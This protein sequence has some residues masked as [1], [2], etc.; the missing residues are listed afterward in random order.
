MPSLYYRVEAPGVNI[1]HTVTQQVVTGLLDELDLVRIFKDSVYILEPFSAYSQYDDGSGAPSLVKN[2]C[3]VEVN[4]IM[5][6]AQVPWPVETPY[7]TTA[8]GLRSDKKGNH[9]PILIDD[10]AQILIEHYTVACGLEMNFTLNFQTYDDA[11]KAFDTIKSKYHGSLIQ[12][13]FDISF[14]YPVSMA[15]L[16][17]L[18]AVYQAKTDYAS[19]TLIDYINDKKVT[20]ISF[21]VRKSELANEDADT[22]LMVRCQQL[23]CLGQ[24]TM[25]QREPDVQRVGQLPDSFTLNFTMVFQFGRPNLVAVHTP[26]S[27][28]NTVLPYALFENLIIN[29]HYNP[30][31]AGVYQDLMVSEFMK[32]SYGD[33]NRSAQIIR[34]PSYDDWFTADNQYVFYEYRPF[35]IAHFT[36]DGPT[37]TIDL[38]QLDDLELHPIVQ[39]I[40]IETGNEVFDYGG[41]FHIG[42]YANDLRLGKELVSISDD[43]ILTIH[44]NREDQSYHLVLSETTALNKTDPKWDQTLIKYRYFFPMTIE[45]NLK[46]LI[47]KRYFYIAYDDSLL[48]LINKLTVV[49]RLKSI[50]QA[51]VNLGEDTNEIFSYTQ[52]PAQLA[53]YLVYKQSLRTD[54]LVAVEGDLLIDSDGGQLLD[55][56]GDLLVDE[57]DIPYELVAQYYGS[58]ASLEGR[59][60]FVAFIE[61]CLLEGYVTL[62][63]IPNQYLRPN[64]S[65]YPYTLASGGYYGFNTP[66]RVFKYNIRAE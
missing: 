14:S 64:Q 53:D 32:R 8:Y 3:D 2:R 62:S 48:M 33:Y 25:E 38:K 56:N 34:I 42:V 9:T 23:Q 26:I 29:S 36:L 31:V 1:L 15:M 5:D 66:I 4:Y 57:S 10:D 44:S 12:T 58:K 43:L 21:D 24:L 41:L 11:T 46:S 30:Q 52:N 49:N 7:T 19:K 51:M 28:D 55:E 60:L 16:Q 35:L 50:L 13:P 22:A 6:K 59:S 27:V 63:T 17:Y 20:E 61:Q 45:R 37:T 39:R 54:Y 65:V 47:D 18:T 40:L